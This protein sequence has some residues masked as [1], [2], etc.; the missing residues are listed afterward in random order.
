MNVRIIFRVRLQLLNGIAA[1][2]K[3]KRQTKVLLPSKLV[4]LS[5]CQLQQE[6]DHIR[7]T[8]GDEVTTNKNGKKQCNQY[9]YSAKQKGG[10]RQIFHRG[11]LASI[12]TMPL[13]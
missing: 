12:S 10:Y 13:R 11:T 9:K 5:E 2:F 3:E 1:V 6:N 8:V 4:S 7:K